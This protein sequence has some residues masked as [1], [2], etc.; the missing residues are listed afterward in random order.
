MKH[1]L[2]LIILA[3][4][5]TPADASAFGGRWKA[6]WC[7]R[8]PNARIC[9]VVP[10]P[11]PPIPPLPPDPPVPPV[12][13][14]PV[15]V[16]VAGLRVL[17]IEE[18]ADRAKITLGQ[19]EILLSTLPGGVR[20]M[21]NKTCAKDAAG[22]P[23]WRLFDKDQSLAKEPPIWGQLRGLIVS[24]S[25]TPTWVISTPTGNSVATL[26]ATPADALAALKAVT[27]PLPALFSFAPSQPPCPN[28]PSGNCPLG[29]FM[30]IPSLPVLTPPLP[31]AY[32]P[33]VTVY[34]QRVT[35]WPRLRFFRQQ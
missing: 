5:L 28:C 20:D 8:H 14:G 3:A 12:P 31:F 13:P 29:R 32:T 26:P 34:R 17:I 30:A 15:P 23:E 35:Y 21:L 6:R 2:L 7:A 22:N 25:P 9:Q 27:P 11:V 10:V 33:P 4:F 16:P 19:R 18:T 24:G 1:L